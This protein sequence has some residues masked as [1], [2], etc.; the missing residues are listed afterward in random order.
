MIFRDLGRSRRPLLQDFEDCCYLRGVSG[1]KKLSHV[2]VKMQLLT[3]FFSVV[4]LMFFRVLA[5]Q[6]FL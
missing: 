4:F 1:T 6:V 2:N 5:F 3:H